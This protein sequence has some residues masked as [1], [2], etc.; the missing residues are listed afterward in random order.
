VCLCQFL[1]VN[2]A[3]KQKAIKK[4]KQLHEQSKQKASKH[5]KL[6]QSKKQAK[7]SEQK[8]SSNASKRSSNQGKKT[9]KGAYTAHPKL[10]SWSQP[11]CNPTQCFF[12]HLLR[13]RCIF[14]RGEM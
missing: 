6:K 5:S 2:Q 10:R 7:Q 13:V 4:S 14:G 8:Q 1:L 9:N 12:A 11:N 3:S